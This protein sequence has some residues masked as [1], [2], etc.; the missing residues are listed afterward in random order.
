[1]RHSVNLIGPTVVRLRVQRGWTQDHLVG[2]LQRCHIHMT[3]DILAS[4]ET[5]RGPVHDYHIAAFA[6][7]FDIPIADLFPPRP[8][9]PN[10][11]MGLG[12]AC[13]RC[14]LR[15]PFERRRARRRRQAGSPVACRSLRRPKASG[16]PNPPG[17]SPTQGANP[18]EP[19][20]SA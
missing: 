19:P 7:V 9:R 18:H 12:G 20:G 6:I 10:C 1:M 8:F 3:R 4:I 5:G 14:L 13:P 17:A 2:R 11:R 16:T 15:D